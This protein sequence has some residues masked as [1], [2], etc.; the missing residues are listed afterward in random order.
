[1]QITGHPLY[2]VLS[3]HLNA[4]D[5]YPVENFHSI[6]RSKTKFTDTGEQIFR[7]ARETD[8]CKN[9]RQEFQSWFVSKRKHA[10]CPNKIKSLKLQAAKLLISKFERIGDNPGQAKMIRRTR[11][12]KKTLTKWMLPNIFGNEISN[13][14]LPLAYNDPQTMPSNEK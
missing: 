8:A 2:H 9:D 11:G 1:M 4:F 13:E 7:K 12:Q 5:E 3:N 10:F 14:V 6:L